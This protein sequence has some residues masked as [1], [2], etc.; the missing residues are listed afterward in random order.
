MSHLDGSRNRRGR[1]SLLK[2]DGRWWRVALVCLLI[3]GVI[4]VA[5]APAA[6]T[7]ILSTP[8]EYRLRMYHTHTGE[9]LDI[10]YRRGDTYI[11]EAIT[12]LERHLRDHRTGEIHRF[13]LRLF[14][15]LADLTAVV[16][17]PSAVI[18]VICGYRTPRS[19]ALLRQGSSG[20]AGQSLHLEAK[21]VDIR[22]PG[23]RTS[24]LRDAA[25]SLHRGGVGYYARSD[26]IH[27]DVGRVRR[28]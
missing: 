10:V 15:L 16:G 25:L 26:F 8:K 14:D 17:R 4:P 9:D 12:C 7:K 27:V 5:V 18:E 19:N 6:N 11:P 21:A 3:G 13:D 20:V 28:W 22:M 1:E 24:E 23:V 2:L